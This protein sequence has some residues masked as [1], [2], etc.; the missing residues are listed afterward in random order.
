MNKRGILGV[1]VAILLAGTLHAQ[2]GAVFEK[3]GLRFMI[4]SEYPF[5]V[6]VTENMYPSAEHVNIPY[7]VSYGLIN[8]IV[9]SVGPR[10]F[11]FD[12]LKSVNVSHSVNW[13]RDACF[14]STKLQRF[15][16]PDDLYEIHNSAFDRC[17]ELDTVITNRKLKEIHEY[18]FKDCHNLHF[19]NFPSTLQVIKE[20]A[21]MACG[22]VNL[23]LPDVPFTMGKAAF[24]GCD[25]L[26]VLNLGSGITDIPEAAFEGHRLPQIIIPDQVRTIGT[27]AFKRQSS[28]RPLVLVLLGK[29]VTN[30]ER[31]AFLTSPGYINDVICLAENPPACNAEA[32]NEMTYNYGNLYVPKN[33]INAYKEAETWKMF[34][35]IR[36]VNNEMIDG[37][38]KTESRETESPDIYN[39][40]GHRITRPMHGINIINGKKILK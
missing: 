40:S 33:S 27:M 12:N 8:Y 32:F 34:K 31:Q 28:F 37:I 25:S 6:E 19:I 26:A 35:N 21:F 17:Y 16:C 30:I 36:E 7:N 24:S 1:G 29:G 39:L 10:A 22:F 4:R 11:E 38:C 23:T 3:E 13:L 5:H 14:R 15:V 9:E 20:H 2:V 18:A